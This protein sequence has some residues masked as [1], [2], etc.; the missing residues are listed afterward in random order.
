MATLARC[1]RWMKTAAGAGGEQ[2][3]QVWC[4]D[5]VSLEVTGPRREFV[6]FIETCWSHYPAYRCW[7]PHSSPQSICRTGMPLRWVIQ[8]YRYRTGKSLPSFIRCWQ[9]AGCLGIHFLFNHLL[10]VSRTHIW[11][12]ESD[13]WSRGRQFGFRPFH[14]RVR[15]TQPSIP[16]G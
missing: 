15:S 16:S 13:L 3:F 4:F 7:L 10:T 14:C 11:W 12:V 1:D 8:V 5:T 6:E 2:S 9:V